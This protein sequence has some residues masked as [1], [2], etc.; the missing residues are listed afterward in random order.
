MST[1][2]KLVLELNRMKVEAK[3]RTGMVALETL[4]RSL[5]ARKTLLSI[6]GRYACFL[7][8]FISPRLKFDIFIGLMYEKN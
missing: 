2:S 6:G 4:E 3:D 5:E 1:F 7:G 8:Y